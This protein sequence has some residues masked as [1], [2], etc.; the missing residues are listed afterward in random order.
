MIARAILDRVGSTLL[1]L[2]AAM[3]LL[4]ALTL[5]IP[6]SPAE[7]ILGPRATPDAIA[8]ITRQM[9]LDRPIWERLLRFFTLL[10]SGEFGTDIISGRPI[11]TMILDVLPFT[12]ALT[13]AVILLALL[14][15]VPAGIYAA[16]R[17]DGIGDRLLALGSVSF[18]ALPNFVVAIGLLMVFS[19]WLDWLPVDGAG[20]PG[21]PGDELLHLVL[22]AL[23]VALGW[24]GYIAR[25]VRSA[26]LE[27]LGQP[28]MR[29]ARAFGIGPGRLVYF[30]A[31]RNAAI[32][33]L[34]VL[35]VG[36]GQLLGGAVFAEIIFARPGMG[37]LIFNA[38]NDRNYP[39]V[40][41]SVF[42]IVLL[43]VATN[44][45]VDALFLWLDP[46][47]RGRAAA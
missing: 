35:G 14:L 1:V 24:I 17:P 38:I 7:A 26:M 25:L 29:T 20:L 23:A 3:L 8:A 34:A 5:I 32:P 18:V 41:A 33:V 16:R 6:G 44:L 47:L 39:V 37:S 12:I 28:Y 15:G 9:G 11:G 43:F 13:A 21:D 2:V 31:L 19:L 22:P 10:L 46:R 30:Y 42:V 4:F 36:I 40:Q 45:A 27:V